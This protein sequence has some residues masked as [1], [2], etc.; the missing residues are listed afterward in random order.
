MIDGNTIVAL[1]FLACVLGYLYLRSRVKK[2]QEPICTGSHCTLPDCEDHG[3]P[4]PDL[5]KQPPLKPERIHE[6][7]VQLEA[8]ME[9]LL[10]RYRF[11]EG[12]FFVEPYLQL[13][14]QDPSILNQSFEILWALP[15][16][17][18]RTCQLIF[19]QS[20][21]G[22]RVDQSTRVINLEGVPPHVLYFARVQGFTPGSKLQYAIE[23]GGM[24]IF[25]S[26]AQ[27][28]IARQ[29]QQQRFAVV[30]DMGEG[31]E[32][33]K[34]IAN[35]IWQAQPSLVAITGDVVYSRGRVKEYL[36]RLFPVFNG[37]PASSITGAPIMRSVITFSCGG[38]HCFGRRRSDTQDSLDDYADLYAYFIYLSMPQNG[39]KKLGAQTSVPVL[40]GKDWRVQAFLDAAGS[41]YPSQAN[42]SFNWGSA[43]WLVL[44]ANG[45]MNWSEPELR[46]W[47]E[48]ELTA[49]KADSNCVWRFVNLH[50]PAFTSQPKHKLEVEVRKL[51]DLFAKYGVN[52][53]FCGHSHWYERSY[54]LGYN[55]NRKDRDGN[56]GLDLSFDGITR[57]FPKGIINIVSGAGGAQLNDGKVS[58]DPK[59][60]ESFTCKI[61]ADRHS[62]TLC[63]IDG[64][65]L[66]I[67]QIDEDG[68]VIDKIVVEQR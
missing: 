54:P 53:V 40:N 6:S 34:Q 13:G 49:A 68:T 37:V 1:L 18:T 51:F 26:T 50:Q 44:D 2:T 21:P 52:I 39:P 33:Q 22:I 14:S 63:D 10:A 4:R 27:T 60:W 32:G 24:K 41:R 64:K 55:A 29:S 35:L 56:M 15:L 31:S 61:V 66:T 20:Q 9:R 42:F 46:A 48:R 5:S 7:E 62:Y 30:G 3:P 38:N 59:L 43:F 57:R 28:P 36:A 17:E 25:Y 12:E 45:Y 47:V 58:R 8:R 65:S 23:L 67:Q 19:E 16:A 11:S